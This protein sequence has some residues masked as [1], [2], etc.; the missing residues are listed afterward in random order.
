MAAKLALLCNILMCIVAALLT[1]APRSS[2]DSDF[3]WV[4]VANSPS[5]EA[6][7]WQ[8]S[9]NPDVTEAMAL[10]RCAVL[11]HANDCEIVASGPNCVAIAW[12][13]DEPLNHP[14]GAAADTPLD[15]LNAAIAAAGP[16]ANDTQVRCS[17]QIEQRPQGNPATNG[18]RPQIV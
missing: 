14:H 12:D 18:L 6:L 2:A 16:F 7:D 13:V 11:Q 4:A 15:A 8:V 10:R 5:R 3:G 17:Y 1:I 9:A